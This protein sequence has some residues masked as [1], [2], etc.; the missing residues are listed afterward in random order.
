MQVNFFSEPY[1]LYVN[2]IN[3]VHGFSQ[4]YRTM[5]EHTKTGWWQVV[6]VGKIKRIP[7][8]PIIKMEVFL[9]S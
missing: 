9:E 1:L 8:G 7:Y 3:R 4:G 2:S 5:K 6:F